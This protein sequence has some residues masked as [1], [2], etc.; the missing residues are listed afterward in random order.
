MDGV[1]LGNAVYIC[2][3]FPLTV[4]EMMQQASKQSLCDSL[5]WSVIL[6]CGSTVHNQILSSGNQILHSHP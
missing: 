3:I 4:L 2:K 1:G 5:L 6:C